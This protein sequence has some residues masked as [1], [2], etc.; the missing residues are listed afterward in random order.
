M[1]PPTRLEVWKKLQEDGAKTFEKLE[2]LFGENV[3]RTVCSL[4]K[5][6][7]ISF[8]LGESLRG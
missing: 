6:G 8:T 7:H 3:D 4:K 5:T 1:K 2:S